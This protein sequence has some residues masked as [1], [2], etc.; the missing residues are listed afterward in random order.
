MRG[1]S[2]KGALVVLAVLALGAA[3]VLA[4]ATI[5]AEPTL[6]ADRSPALAAAGAELYE[7]SCAECHGLEMRGTDT[8]PS[9]L[10]IVYEPN[11][12]SDTA[13]LSAIRNGAQSHHWDFGPMEPVEGLSDEDV[14][15]IVTFVRNAQASEGFEP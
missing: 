4:M 10:S 14:T 13:F 2:S 15:A 8:G 9:L 7:A 12:H 5:R 3:V 11:H 1:F 6:S